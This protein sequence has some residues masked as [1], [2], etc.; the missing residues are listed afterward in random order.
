MKSLAHT[1]HTFEPD[2][3]QY[4]YQLDFSIYNVA[5]LYELI[6]LLRPKLRVELEV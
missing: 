4:Q 2:Q 3:M 6:H 5:K 1:G